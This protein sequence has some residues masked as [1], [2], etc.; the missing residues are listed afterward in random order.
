[1]MLCQQCIS[2]IH[3]V[4]GQPDETTLLLHQ[5]ILE[6]MVLQEYEDDGAAFV[7][8][9]QHCFALFFL[10]FQMSATHSSA[11]SCSSCPWFSILIFLHLGLQLSC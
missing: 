10:V 3:V 11:S 9:L 5:L 7:H 4:I 8:H 6:P 1:M 2:E